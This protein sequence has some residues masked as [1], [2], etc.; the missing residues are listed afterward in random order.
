MKI[1]KRILLVLLVILVIAQF[2]RTP[3]NLSGNTINDISKN[4]PVPPDVHAILT[5]ACFDCHSNKT[6]YPWY[7][8]V[9]PVAWWLGDHIKEGKREINFNEFSSYRIGKQYRKMEACMD[10]VKKGDMPLGSYTI[11]HRDARLT[12]AEKSTLVNWFASVHD[13]IQAKYPADSLI[14]KRPPQKS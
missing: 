2:F 3:K 10:E 7:S 14:V 6:R 1:L 8:E 5:K 9:Q 13:A 12:D 4:Y 11:I